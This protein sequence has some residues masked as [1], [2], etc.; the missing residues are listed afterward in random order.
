MYKCTCKYCGK[1]FD[2]RYK[3][4]Q[5]CKKCKNRPCEICGK[6]FVHEW[7]YDQHCCSKACREIFLKDPERNKVLTEQRKATIQ[8][9]Y[10]VDNV[11]KLDAV[12]KKIQR[13]KIDSENYF[14]EKQSTIETRTKQ[15]LLQINVNKLFIKT[16]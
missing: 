13:S 15:S 12:R 16:A 10:G 8:A 11:S 5:V 3:D 1:E 2:S 9:K 7:P 14:A 6:P 4:V